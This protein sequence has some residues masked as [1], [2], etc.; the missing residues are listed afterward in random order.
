MQSPEEYL[1]RAATYFEQSEFGA[2][3]QAAA[4]GL[5]HEP[6][7]GQ[8]WLLQAAAEHQL[9][10]YDVARQ[11]FEQAALLVPLNPETQCTLADCYARTGRAEQARQL[12]AFLADDA[13][14]PAEVL[15]RV[16]A[17]FGQIGDLDRALNVCR[18]AAERDPQESAPFFGAAYYL[19]R[20]GY[21]AAAILPW[22][23][24]AFE[25]EPDVSLYRTSLALLLAECGGRDEAYELLR[26]LPVE[27]CGCPCR[28]RRM[29]AV[30]Q[31]V[32]DHER[33]QEC[34]NYLRRAR[35]ENQ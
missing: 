16:A 35:R 8:L 29:M 3:A 21:P 23:R 1:S 22:A 7:H 27:Q 10:N 17:G 28:L 33:W 18:M 24:R 15:P 19:R 32:G 5:K 26:E 25:L 6:D 31:A 4:A 2:A 34:S 14:L 30:F 12:L 9:A 11:A 13:Q 20:L